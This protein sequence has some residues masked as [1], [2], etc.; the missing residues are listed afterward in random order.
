[1][2]VTLTNPLSP[3]TFVPINESN[4]V[5][6]QQNLD[7]YPTVD[8]WI[9]KQLR[10]STKDL[11]K[12]CLSHLPF[13]SWIYRYNLTWLVNDLIAGLTVGAIVIPQ[14]MAYAG[15]AKLPVQ[16][17]LYSSLMGVIVYWIFATSKVNKFICF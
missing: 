15:L 13:I 16:F 1:M 17:G 14:G 6:H 8:G 3:D 5:D 9:K 7:Q 4:S 11:S 12:H 10:N 2:N